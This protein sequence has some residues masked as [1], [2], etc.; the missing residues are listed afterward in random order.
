MTS[1]RIKGCAFHRHLSNQFD[2]W[3]H[4]SQERNIW[5]PVTT[6][7]SKSPIAYSR[8]VMSVP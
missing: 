8:I 3:Y 7:I 4:T 5:L 6:Y 2:S 1:K